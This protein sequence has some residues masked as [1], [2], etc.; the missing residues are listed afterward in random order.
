MHADLQRRLAA[1]LGAVLVLLGVAVWVHWR[2]TVQV[3]ET[4]DWVTHTREVLGEIELVLRLNVDIE[5]GL[6]GYVISGDEQLLDPFVK[7]VQELPSALGRLAK[8]TTDNATQRQHVADLEAAVNEHM[9]FR[10]RVLDLVRAQGFEVTRV[11]LEPSEGKRRLDKIR[12]AVAQIR[13]VEQQLLS[14]R[15]QASRNADRRAQGTL[16]ALA[17]L[18]VALVL[19]TYLALR[20]AISARLFAEQALRES[21]QGMAITLQSIGDAV[22]ATD[23]DGRITRMNRLAE[24]LTGWPLAQARGRP[25]GDVFRIINEQTR[26]PAAVPVAAVLATGMVQSLANHT[27]LIARNGSETAIADS[28]APIRRADGEVLGVVLV[29]RDVSEERR[30]RQ[31]ILDLNASLDERVRE[32]TAEL[33]RSEA[34][35]RTTLDNLIEGCQ[36][37][38]F[39]WRY[40]YINAAAAAHGRSSVEALLGRTMMEAYPGIDRT[41]VFATLKRSMEGRTTEEIENEFVYADGSSSVFQ[42]VVQPVPE[43]IFVFSMDISARKHVEK[44]RLATQA[45]LERRVAERTDELR[46]ATE[47]L[48]AKNAQLEQASRLKSEFL[49]NMSHELRTPLNAIIGFSEILREGVAGELTPSQRE[50]AGDINSSGHHLL[51]LISDILDLAKIEAGSMSLEREE[52]SLTP[53]LESGLAVVRDKAIARNLDLRKAIDPELGLIEGDSRKLKQIVYNLLSNAVKFSD[54]GGR[55]SLSARKVDRVR[56]DMAGTAA[57]RTL[58]APSVADRTFVE[59]SVQDTGIGIAAAD[60]TRLFEPFV[61]VDASMK[62]RHDGT[63]LGLALVRRIV[64]LHGGGLAVESTPGRGSRFTVWLPYRPVSRPAGNMA[65]AAPVIKTRAVAG[66]GGVE[67]E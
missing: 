56:I 35:F 50:F 52:V 55:V 53:L 43:G 37:I 18:T 22:L 40:Q 17:L 65:D 51:A 5:T 30:A 12:A 66:E 60:L 59:I 21:E 10:R 29:F 63:G 1:S 34:R 24:Q 46:S 23:V 4:A 33:R 2:N 36:I 45:E 48:A 57:G 64:D 32:R 62:R 26:T 44:L 9:D 27:V 8:L 14:Q 13:G 58:L 47:E 15:E 6:R 11:Q 61:Q 3:D 16:A 39:D 25:V 67:G 31:A 38:G 7:A 49:A 20:R 28:A 19:G 41:P 42:L 54:P